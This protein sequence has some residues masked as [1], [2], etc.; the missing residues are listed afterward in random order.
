MIARSCAALV[1]LGCL[2]ADARPAEAQC[3]YTVS[4]ASVSAT[5]TGYNGGIFVLTGASCAWTAV[6][7]VAW[8]T[9]TSGASMSGMGSAN[10]SV[11][12]NSSGA[13]RTGTLTV[14]GQT[15][16][17]NQSAN[18]CS[19][20]LSATSLTAPSTGSQ[21]RKGVA[22]GPSGAYAARRRRDRV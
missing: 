7:N 12:A 21:G 22:D 13:V 6:S 4:P 11:A 14:A 9:I 3:T 2:L 15:V 19:Y 20:S 5:S 10:F 1:V 18:S 17:V 8:I 16:T